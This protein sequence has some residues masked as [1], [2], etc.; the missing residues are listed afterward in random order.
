MKHE[1]ITGAVIG[2]AFEVL[3]ELGA[4]FLESVYQKAVVLTRPAIK[5]TFRNYARSIMGDRA[6][7]ERI[8]AGRN[9]V[10]HSFKAASSGEGP[11]RAVPRSPRIPGT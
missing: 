9:G 11:S 3:N 10:D 4:G 5:V 6:D 8:A 2:C 7:T 1:A